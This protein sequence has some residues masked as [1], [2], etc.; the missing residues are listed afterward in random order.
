M[1]EPI[2][3]EAVCTPPRSLT[4]RGW[5]WLC[6][7]SV[8]GASVPA[9]LFLWL[10]AWP[11]LGFMGAEVALVLGLVALHRRATARMEETVQLTPA[12]LRV[13]RRDGAG[14]PDVAELEPYWARL[15]VEEREGTAPLLR[16]VSRG[17]SVEVGRYLSE[18]ERRDFARALEAALAAYRCPVFDNPQ[19]K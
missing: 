6:G 13:R 5:R 7:L 9:L 1:S 18:P 17:R 10:G 2:L 8:L 12:T 3:F 14:R 4:P 16:L 11:V 19:L 15:L